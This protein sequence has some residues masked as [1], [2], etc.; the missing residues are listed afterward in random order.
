MHNLSLDVISQNMYLSPTYISKLFKESTG[1]SPINYL[2][3]LR[4]SKAKQS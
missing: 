1:N 3:K 4:L 2:I